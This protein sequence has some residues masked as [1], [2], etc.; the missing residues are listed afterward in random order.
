[1]EKYKVQSPEENKV[2]LVT[3]CYRKLCKILKTLKKEKGKIIHV[4]GAPGT[5]KSTNIFQALQETDLNVYNMQLNLKSVD[6]T[7]KEVFDNVYDD[8]SND[9]CLKTRKE[10]YKKLSEFD[11][12]L[13]A[14]S[15][16]DSHVFNPKNVGFSQWTD[17]K[18][19]N[20]FYF[21][22]LCINEYLKNKKY[23]K[24]MNLIFQTAWRIRFRGKKYDIFTD[25]GFF[26]KL[27]I[28]MLKRF[29]IVLEISYSRKETTKI[30]KM[31]IP[32]VNE[33]N[34]SR[35]IEKYGCK[36]RFICNALEK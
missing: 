31:H 14:D 19:I 28:Y 6:Q 15:F 12:I 24:N 25:F 22:L 27:I 7:S 30:V 10:I 32:D 13:I 18:G 4:V 20:S 2:F 21:Y 9:L 1:M 33:E 16:H 35:Y 17:K 26:S 8:L 29:F 11:A 5:G 23:F 34:I 3:D 36:P